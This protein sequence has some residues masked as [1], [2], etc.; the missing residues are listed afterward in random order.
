MQSG[1]GNSG[2]GGG[3]NGDLYVVVTLRRHSVFERDGYDLHCE[4]PVTFPQA[5]L[6]ASLDIPTL[7]G[8]KVKF[9]LPAGTQNGAEFTLRGSGIRMLRSSGKGDLVSH[10]LVEVPKN[11]TGEQK[12]LLEAF[13]DSCKDTNYTK[14]KKFF[15][16]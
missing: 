1:E 12:K 7:D 15:G 4:V 10:I 13:A 8:S 11:L 3:P 16:K 14:R 5:A 2:R 6:G 9:D